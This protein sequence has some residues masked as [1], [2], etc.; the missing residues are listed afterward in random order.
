MRL[1]FLNVWHGRGGK[2]F[3]GFIK[4]E[5]EKNDIFCFCEVDPELLE[6]IKDLLPEYKYYYEELPRIDHLGGIIEGQVIFIKKDFNFLEKHKVFAYK[7]NRKDT[8]CVQVSDI[9]IGNKV[10]TIVNVHGKARPGHKKDTPARIRQSQIILKQAQG[11][12]NPR[13]IVGDFNLNPD[14][15]SI[16][17]FEDSGYKNLIK[18]F[19]IKNTRNKLSWEQFKDQ[20]GFTKQFFADFCFVSRDIRVGNFEVPYLEISDHLP[21]ILDFEL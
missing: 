10:L 15:R 1:V 8:G 18:E 19:K 3:P 21:L 12:K 9:G 11:K 17:M 5:S 13:I 20:P 14:T 4:K 2:D 16:N 6:K 7:I